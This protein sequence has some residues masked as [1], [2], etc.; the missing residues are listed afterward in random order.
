MPLN[1]YDS[2]ISTLDGNHHPFRSLAHAAALCWGIRPAITA[3]SELTE[4]FACES[5][6]ACSN[7]VGSAPV[8]LSVGSSGPPDCEFA[9]TNVVE[10]PERWIQHH[11]TL[12]GKCPHLAALAC[13]LGIKE[14]REVDPLVASIDGVMCL[15]KSLPSVV[16]DV[17]NHLCVCVKADLAQ[18]RSL[19]CNST[20]PRRAAPTPLPCSSGRTA[21]LST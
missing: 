11:F 21:I 5:L 13:L 16:L 10:H 20:K 6:H 14:A 18:A 17:L 4:L 19:S 15:A 2:R 8:I 12:A 3:A 9:V 7:T 1:L